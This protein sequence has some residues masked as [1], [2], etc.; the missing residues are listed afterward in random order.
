MAFQDSQTPQHP[1]TPQSTAGLTGTPWHHSTPRHP[2]ASLGAVTQT[3]EFW[4]CARNGTRPPSCSGTWDLPKLGKSQ[5]P[6]VAEAPGTHQCQMQPLRVVVAPGTYQHHSGVQPPK[7]WWHQRCPSPGDGHSRVRC[8]PPSCGGTGD[9]H[10]PGL[11]PTHEMASI[12]STPIS[13][14]QCAWSPRASGSP[15]TQ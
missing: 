11:C 14:Q 13:T 10:S 8:S 9:G 7:L 6:Q 3:G 1:K 2:M 5:P 4:G 12:M 15:D